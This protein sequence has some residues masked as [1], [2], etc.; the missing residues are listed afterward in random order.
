M[1]RAQSSHR[2]CQRTETKGK[3][4][5]KRN[6]WKIMKDLS[7]PTSSC[8]AL[9][10]FGDEHS[11]IILLP[12][13]FTVTTRARHSPGANCYC[14]PPGGN[15]GQVTKAQ[16]KNKLSC[17]KVVSLKEG[18]LQ[19]FWGQAGGRT[20][21]D[22]LRTGRG[23]DTYRPFEDGQEE[24]HLRTFWGQAGGRTPKLLSAALLFTLHCRVRLA[25]PW[26]RWISVSSNSSSLRL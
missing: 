17:T 5:T 4:E 6:D 14:V 22:L 19:T 8:F 9:C 20:P 15:G 18:H 12:F 26:Q 24:G 10:G 25:L 3:P 2:S 23:K 11:G 1:R 7:M 13:V 16:L 21:T